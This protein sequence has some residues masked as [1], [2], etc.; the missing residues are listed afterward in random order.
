MIS[1]TKIGFSFLKVY[2]E[3]HTSVAPFTFAWIGYVFVFWRMTIDWKF[4]DFLI[5]KL[6]I[7]VVQF[8]LQLG[9]F[10]SFPLRDPW[11]SVRDQMW[12]RTH[13]DLSVFSCKQL[14]LHFNSLFARSFFVLIEIRIKES[15]DRDFSTISFS[16]NELSEFLLDSLTFFCKSEIYTLRHPMSH[17]SW[18]KV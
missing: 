7:N 4:L 6:G 3:I 18:G 9:Q 12:D 10:L 1:L 15:S 13:S 16:E 11:N 17:I 8:W 14:F 2:I 5:C